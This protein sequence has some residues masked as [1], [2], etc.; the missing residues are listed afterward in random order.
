MEENSVLNDLIND[1][2]NVAEEAV[3][4]GSLLEEKETSIDNT[5]LFGTNISEDTSSDKVDSDEVVAFDNV[6]ELKRK[7][8]EQRIIEEHNR[9][10]AQTPEFKAQIVFN[11]ILQNNPYMSGQEKRRVRKEC[12][13]NAKKGRYD[14]LF[15]P[16]KIRKREERQKEK[17]DKLNKTPIHT[18]DDITDETRDVLEQMADSPEV[19]PFNK[20]TGSFEN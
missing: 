15:D 13:R 19:P 3:G 1:N 4:I 9:R 8:E 18:V 7:E 2:I 6:A 11:S 12:L 5:A 17:F 14:Y 16:E 10:V 20:E